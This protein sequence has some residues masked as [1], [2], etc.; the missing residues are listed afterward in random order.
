M[1]TWQPIGEAEIGQCINEGVQKLSPSE[2]RFFEAIR[3]NPQKW[4]LD[5]WGNE[6]NGFWVLG[7]I[8]KIVL[9]YNDIEFGFNHSTY[10]EFGVI[11]EYWCDQSDLPDAIKS[12]R[13][14]IEAGIPHGRAGPPLKI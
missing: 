6:G 14:S 2:E 1:D 9:W 13:S 5:P 3:I 8:G 11:E 4:V 7:I 12:L 10:K